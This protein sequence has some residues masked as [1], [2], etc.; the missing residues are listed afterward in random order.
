MNYV[1]KKITCTACSGVRVNPES[2]EF[3]DFC[4]IMVG[5]FTPTQASR[6]LRREHNDPSITIRACE[7]DTDI[8]RMPVL[9]FIAMATKVEDKE[10]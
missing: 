1:S 3:E 9:Q 4:E 7:L 8:Y 10:K 2:H 5:R 6:K